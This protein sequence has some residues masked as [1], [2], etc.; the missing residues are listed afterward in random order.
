MANIQDQKHQEDPQAY[1]RTAQEA[2]FMDPTAQVQALRGIEEAGEVL[3]GIYHSH[4]DGTPDFSAEDRRRALL[5]G[6]PA[7]PEAWYLVVDIH[8]GKTH[9]VQA[10]AWS[11]AEGDFIAAPLGDPTP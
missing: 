8:Q 4:V 11:D 6:R 2:Y 10:F 1:P 9:G 3:R 7:F 5:L